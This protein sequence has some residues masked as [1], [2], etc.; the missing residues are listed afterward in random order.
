MVCKIS[1]HI[2]YIYASYH[3][4]QNGAISSIPQLTQN[5]AEQL[6][7][8]YSSKFRSREEYNLEI[9]SFV[10]YRCLEG[11]VSK[12][13]MSWSLHC[14]S[15]IER[16]AKAYNLLIEHIWLLKSIAKKLAKEVEACGE[17]CTDLW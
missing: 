14:T 5:V 17:E 12:E 9:S 4:P 6:A 3:V 13:E 7:P 1:F 2:S 8:Y 10:A 16:L 15:S 11:Y